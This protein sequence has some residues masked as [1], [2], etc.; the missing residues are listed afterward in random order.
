MYQTTFVYQDKLKV[1]KTT[2][3]QFKLELQAQNCQRNYELYI[4]F[5][6]SIVYTGCFYYYSISNSSSSG[7]NSMTG[8]ASSLNVAAT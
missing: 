3:C 4:R 1:F 7:S 2:I 6:E 8:L 5:V